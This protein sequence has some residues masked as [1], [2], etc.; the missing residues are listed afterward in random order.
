VSDLAIGHVTPGSGLVPDEVLAATVTT[1][2]RGHFGGGGLVSTTADYLRFAAM[3]LNRGVLEGT[4][5]LSPQTTGFMFRNHLP[6]GADL[7]SYGRPMNAESPLAGVG[8]G[9]GVSVVLDPVRAGYFTSAGEFGWGGAASTVF[10]VDPALDLVVVFMTQALPAVSLPIRN[11]L[12]QLV[13][14]AIVD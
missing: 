9:L 11:K 3:L 14:Q 8:H 1:P 2:G 7:E 5:I 6:G 12:H 13:H 10:W 4:R